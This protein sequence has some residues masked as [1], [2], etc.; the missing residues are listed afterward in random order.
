M[1]LT[2]TTTMLSLVMVLPP[3]FP[4]TAAVPDAA[5]AE[6]ATKALSSENYLS[7]LIT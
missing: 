7:P 2:W 3:A 6:P 5:Q 1:T 4:Q